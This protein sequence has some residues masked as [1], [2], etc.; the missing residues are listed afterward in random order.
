[1][2]IKVQMGDEIP[3]LMNES[4]ERE[5]I[6]IISMIYHSSFPTVVLS[7]FIHLQIGHSTLFPWCL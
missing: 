5:P 4:R 1:M 2:E 3:V 7:L 6:D